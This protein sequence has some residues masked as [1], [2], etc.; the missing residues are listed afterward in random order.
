MQSFWQNVHP[1]FPLLHRPSIIQA[2]RL[3]Y[4]PQGAAV[5]RSQG[6]DDVVHAILNII[7]AL[8]IQ[9]DKQ[10]PSEQR[11]TT[12][13]TF[14]QKSLTFVSLSCIDNPTLSHVQLF[15]LTAIY[16]QSTA[17]A[18]RCWDMVGAGLR[19]ATSLG[20]F[21]EHDGFHGGESQLQREM[22]RRVWCCCAVLDK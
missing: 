13:N 10:L 9:Y 14:Y 5:D 12:A 17:Y 11:V 2:Y 3:L 20:L 22:R 15:L 19:V 7:F 4:E 21:R 8:G 6:D 18:N 1:I 16:L